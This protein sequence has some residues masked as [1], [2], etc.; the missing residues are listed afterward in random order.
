MKT[1]LFLYNPHAGKA[2]IASRLHEIVHI[3]QTAGYLTTVYA[4]TGPRDAVEKLHELA[5]QFD[6]IVCAGG[7]GTLSEAI[8]GLIDSNY[9]GNLGYIPAGSTND[10]S[11]TLGIPSTELEAARIAV[12]GS[13]VACDIGSF[14]RLHQFVY[15]A[16]FGIFT[17]VSYQTPQ[18]FKNMLGHL[19][20]VLEGIRSL[21]E[22]ANYHLR[23]QWD[24]GE[25]E[26]EFIYGAVSNSVS[27]GGFPNPLSEQ[28]IL[29]DGVFEVMLVRS[30]HSILELNG[31]IA[32][33]LTSE[34]SENVICFQT[35]RLSIQSA[36][37]IPWTL[38]GENG[39]KHCFVDIR[40]LHNA[41]NLCCH[42]KPTLIE[43][44]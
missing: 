35:S 20:Y 22:V 34:P 21:T 15:V 38:D 43:N 29:D 33:L 39:G 8:S 5:G 25:M 16:A 23:L 19:A 2:H 28:V 12:N 13:A 6:H 14:N 30:P 10:F 31:I 27:I 41:I 4:T 44:K 40:N 17:A 3:F 18:E 32:E 37:E 11:K 1:L 7:D 42:V 9:P 36:S 24:Q 26:G